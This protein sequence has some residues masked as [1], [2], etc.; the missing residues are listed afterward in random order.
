MPLVVCEWEGAGEVVTP[1]PLRVVVFRGLQLCSQP[2]AVGSPVEGIFVNC[3][4]FS[5]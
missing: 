5:H 4:Q 1:V 3:L 2:P